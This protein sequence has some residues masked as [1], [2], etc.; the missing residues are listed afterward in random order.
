MLEE[1]TVKNFGIIENV[2][3]QFANKLNILT[4]ETGA[5]KSILV[6]ALRFGL[7]ERFQTSHLRDNADSC[8]VEAVFHLPPLFLKTLPDNDNIPFEDNTLIIQRTVASDGRNRIKINGL[9]VTAAQLKSIGDR[10]IDFHGPYDHQ[11]LLA[12]HEH[13]VILDAL[14]DFED[15]LTRYQSL[16]KEY[17]AIQNKITELHNLAQSRERDIDLLAHQI[18]ELEQVPLN[19]TH[20]DELT[21]AQIK[22]ANAEKLY[23][24]LAQAMAILENDEASL[25]LILSKTMKPL[26]KLAAI[27]DKAA[28]LLDDLS[29]LQDKARELVSGLKD[30]GESLNFNAQ[31]AKTVND[32]F[33][34]YKDIQKKYG[35]SIE[36]ARK[37]YEN[38]KEKYALL[39][40]YEQHEETL[41]EDLAD[42]K[43]KLLK[44]AKSLTQK[45]K[46]TASLLKKTIEK[47]LQELGFKSILFEV[48]ME[49]I[50]PG[51]NGTDKVVFFISTNAGES[52]KPLAEIVSSGEA[53]RLMLAI[54]RSLMKVDSVPVLIFDEIDA[55][56]GGRLGTVVGTKLREI[57]DHRQVILITHLPQIAA[58]AQT[59]F[60]ISKIVEKGRT[61]TIVEPLQGKQRLEE[62]AHM[63][64]GDKI[65]PVALKH[66]EDML[67]TAHKD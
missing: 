34:A 51:P 27:D 61:K 9:T 48:R 1:L 8:S 33:D 41:L 56:I 37:F 63:M 15:N 13:Q 59:H 12:E 58:F 3:I 54:K 57:A 6:D 28:P 10:I 64:T 39:S 60:K 29:T 22:I 20:F 5:G 17:C 52:L 31:D 32:Q 16:Y 38:A 53:A 45:R 40:D 55:Q 2:S 36:D 46:K 65:T 23:D 7:G 18:K 67:A 66:A 24:N 35:P 47:E 49:T 62:V 44:I 42:K 14:T 19:Q 11:Q 50:A 25:E 43:E 30:Y 26:D 4:G 21:Q